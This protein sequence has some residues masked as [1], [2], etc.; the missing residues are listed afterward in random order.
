MTY[1]KLKE[2]NRKLPKGLSRKRKI[3]APLYK[4]RA[5]AE[6]RYREEQKHRN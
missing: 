6:R 5:E 4:A 1:P 3:V 2:P